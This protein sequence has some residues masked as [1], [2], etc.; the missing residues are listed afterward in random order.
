[1]NMPETL[2]NASNYI[3]LDM[4]YIAYEYIIIFYIHMQYTF[5]CFYYFLRTFIFQP[6]ALY[7]LAL[8][9]VSVCS[10]SAELT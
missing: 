9:S 6:F 5:C 7:T 4:K 3:R 1:M 8:R 10:F 2:M